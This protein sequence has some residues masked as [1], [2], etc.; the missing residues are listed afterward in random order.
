MQNT[1]GN[2]LNVRGG[3]CKDVWSS[4]Y[5]ESG[6]CLKHTGIMVEAD[7]IVSF[8]RISERHANLQGFEGQ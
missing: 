8:N 2:S 5:T 1:T 3:K 4:F 6:K 7:I